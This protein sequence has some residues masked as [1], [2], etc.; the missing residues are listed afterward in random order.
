MLNK[1]LANKTQYYIVR[2]IQHSQVRFISGNIVT[3]LMTSKKWGV[4]G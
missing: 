4:K 3:Q 2:L 1:I